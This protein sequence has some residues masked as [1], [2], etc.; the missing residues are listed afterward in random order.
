MSAS[1]SPTPDD[2]RDDLS[3]LAWVHDELRRSLDAAH[4][5]LRRFVKETEVRSGFDIDAV[6]PA[7]LRNARSQIQ[8]GVG[9]LE[10]IGQPAAAM[11]LRASEALVQ[12]F[13]AKPHKLTS[14]VI[15]D[16]EHASFR[17]VGD[18]R[19]TYE[20]SRLARLGG[21]RPT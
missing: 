9:A 17:D 21:R 3:A 11:V 13:V 1:M 16:I 5:A 7:V 8:Q 19:K 4:K 15:D 20:Q 2:S 10:L 6:D 12:R 18:A 14:L